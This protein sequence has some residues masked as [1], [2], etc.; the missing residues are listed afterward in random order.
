MFNVTFITGHYRAYIAVKGPL[1]SLNT[2]NLTLIKVK[3]ETLWIRFVYEY[4]DTHNSFSWYHYLRNLIY[5][6]I[7]L[8]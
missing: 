5:S 2:V 8:Y 3:N 4:T 1:I 7:K 6:T